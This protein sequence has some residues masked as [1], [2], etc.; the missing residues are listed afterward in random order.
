MRNFKTYG[1][2]KLIAT[3]YEPNEQNYSYSL[4]VSED[5]NGDGV[6]TFQDKPTI[7]KLP[8]NG[9]FRSMPASNS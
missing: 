4:E 6:I 7:T 5:T 3:H 1:L 9:D 2:K 8:C